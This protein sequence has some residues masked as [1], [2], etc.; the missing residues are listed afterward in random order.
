MQTEVI[1]ADVKNGIALK[2]T[3]I[4]MTELITSISTWMEL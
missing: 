2:K 1:E 3:C 4:G